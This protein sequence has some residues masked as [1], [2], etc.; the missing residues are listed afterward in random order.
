M[1]YETIETLMA[2][3][4]KALEVKKGDKIGQRWF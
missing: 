2:R 4:R 1:N 3:I